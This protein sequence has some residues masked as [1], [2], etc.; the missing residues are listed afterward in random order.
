MGWSEIDSEDNVFATTGL[1]PVGRSLVG[2]RRLATTNKR[3]RRASFAR[4]PV[5]ERFWLLREVAEQ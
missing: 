2:Y 5:A 3:D 1:V 4:P